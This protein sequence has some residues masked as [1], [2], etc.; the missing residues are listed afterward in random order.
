M[1]KRIRSTWGT[2]PLRMGPD[3]NQSGHR[4]QDYTDAELVDLAKKLT[5]VA[6]S[7]LAANPYLNTPPTKLRKD[8]KSE[9]DTSKRRQMT[10][11]LGAWRLTVPGPF[12][13]G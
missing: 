12:R 13:K 1:S 6:K 11:A 8:L 5:K 7:I 3:Y 9:S 4:P 10:E 2:G